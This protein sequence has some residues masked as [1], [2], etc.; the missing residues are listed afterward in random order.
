MLQPP[1]LPLQ[2]LASLTASQELFP[3]EVNMHQQLVM[4]KMVFLSW[5]D[6]E[7]QPR[8]KQPPHPSGSGASSLTNSPEQKCFRSMAFQTDKWFVCFLL[9][10]FLLIFRGGYFAILKQRGYT[11]LLKTYTRHLMFISIIVYLLCLQCF[12]S[13]RV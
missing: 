2:A 8:T 9:P 12:V 7:L 6:R 10:S 1:G 11:P 13:L 4:W 5:T 3:T